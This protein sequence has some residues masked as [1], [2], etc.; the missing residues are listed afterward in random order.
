MAGSYNSYGGHSTL[1]LIPDFLL[2]DAPLFGTAIA[3]LTV[4]FHFA[5][6]GPPRPSLEN[7]YAKF[8]ADRLKLPKVAFRRSHGKMSIDVSS[9]LIDGSDL[10]L[11]R[12]VSLPLFRAAVAEITEALRLMGLRLTKRDDFNLDAFLA[13]CLRREERLPRD[14]GTMTALAA[15]LEERRAAIRAAM[16]PWERLGI[17]WRDY[18]PNARRILDAPFY[19]EQAN[20]FAPHGN[21]TGADLLSDYKAWLKRQP[22]GNPVD[23]FWNLMARWGFSPNSTDPAIRSALDEAAIGL[24]FAELKLRAQCQPSVAALAREAV[25]RQRQE[26][27]A[28]TEST[29]RVDRLRSL[30]LVVAKLPGAV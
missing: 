3:E 21:D 27:L 25:H 28:A 24:A 26:A 8:H 23:Y 2:T 12:G 11:F 30:E 14:E 13:H 7:L 17:D 29:Y 16:S 1:S 18:H 19:W 4:T 22:S 6:S 9:N 15:E 20:D 5:T 10:E